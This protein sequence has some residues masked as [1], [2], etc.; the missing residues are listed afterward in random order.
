MKT[1]K[2]LLIISCVIAR[3]LPAMNDTTQNDTT[4]RWEPEDAWLMIL[5]SEKTSIYE[6]IK[7]SAQEVITRDLIS[8][9]EFKSYKR[10]DDYDTSLLNLYKTHNPTSKHYENAKKWVLAKAVENRRRGIY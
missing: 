1:S 8:I 9:P 10:R 6:H 4:E 7:D 3:S 5:S 2:L